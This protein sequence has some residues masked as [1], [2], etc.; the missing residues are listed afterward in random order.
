M[1]RAAPLPCRYPGCRVLVVKGYCDQH[2]RATWKRID[3]HRGS[4][5]ERGYDAA[6][7]SLRAWYLSLHPLCECDACQAGVKR[8]TAATVV[9][10]RI[11]IAERPDL[12]LDPSNLRA[13]NKVCHDRHTARTQGFAQ[14]G[15][16]GARSA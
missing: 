2:K 10:H 11:S 8:V 9:D 12:R 6:W 16:V 5:K 15:R 4:S 14:S 1:P 3:Q 13:M 7:R